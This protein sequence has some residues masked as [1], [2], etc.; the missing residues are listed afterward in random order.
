MVAAPG[1]A[2]I[3]GVPGGAVPV[4]VGVELEGERR[5]EEELLLLL[6]VVLL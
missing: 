1:P 3:G 6:L 2:V 4:V 5:E